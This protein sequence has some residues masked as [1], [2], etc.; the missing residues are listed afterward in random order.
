MNM[1]HMSY[2]EWQVA[3]IENNPTMTYCVGCASKCPECVGLGYS[4]KHS[5]N[6]CN[7]TGLVDDTDCIHD[8]R[9]D[10][11]AYDTQLKYDKNMVG[12]YI[13]SKK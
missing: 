12:E 3:C 10:R 8:M 5:C 7:G 9:L 1:N 13:T 4:S 6:T 11:Q 2:K